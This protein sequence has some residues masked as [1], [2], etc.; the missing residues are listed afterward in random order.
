V[1]RT[2]PTAAG[3]TYTSSAAVTVP[4]LAAGDYY[5]V[6]VADADREVY[7][8]REGNND[9]AAPVRIT[10]PDLTPT[11]LKTPT[12][13]WATGSAWLS[14]TVKNAGGGP[15]IRTWKDRL[16]LSSS[17]SC[18]AGAKTLITVA[19]AAG[20]APGATYTK[21]KMITVPDLPAG[22]Y[23]LFVRTDAQNKLW[24][25]D[26]SNNQTAAPVTL[27]RLAP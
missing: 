11:A 22:S 16:Y 27:R 8:S 24:E 10:T 6:V 5:I 3:T 17:P 26:E 21:T 4:A 20:L 7:E 23:Y 13:V 2:T 19:A 25:A 9:R 15:A 1:R 14:W 12:T 18:C